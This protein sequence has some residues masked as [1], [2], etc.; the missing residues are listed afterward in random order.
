[1]TALLLAASVWPVSAGGQAGG[2]EAYAGRPVFEV[3]DSVRQQGYPI[4]YSSQLVPPTLTVVAEPV[5][6]EP[7][8]MLAEI[9]APHGLALKSADGIFLVVREEGAPPATGSGSLL[10]ISRD[11][12]SNLLKLPVNIRGSPPLPAAES[13]GAGVYRFAG[14]APGRYELDISAHGYEPT[15]KSV[16]IQSTDVAVLSV[17]LS[18]GVLELE[19]LT[20]STSRYILFANSQFFVD[21]RAIENLPDIG[22]DPVRSVHRLP[23]AAAGGWSAKSYFRGGEANETAI[24]LNGLKLLD[25]FH[26]RDYQNVFS[27]IDARSISGV[28]AYTGGFPANYGDRMSGLLILESQQP[29]K[30]RHTE[31]GISIFNTS[32][33]T[34]GYSDGG[35]FDWLLSARDSNLKYVLDKDLG[36]PSYNDIFMSAGF[37]PSPDTRL[38]LNALRAEDSILVVTESAPEEREQA[39][40]DTLNQSLW[41]TMENQWTPAVSSVTVLSS[42]SFENDRDGIVLDPEQLVGWVMD[43]RDV[44]ILELKQDWKWQAGPRHLLQFGFEARD[45]QAGYRYLS[46]AEYFGFYLAYPGVQESIQRDIT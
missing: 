24:Y 7:L 13:L 36:E 12:D 10:I 15:R 1:M 35:D 42:S 32:V 17:R 19:A 26:V 8:T 2:T 28:E 30:S 40:S 9:L 34:S 11:Q 5:S 33:L 20:V 37:N 3:L 16:E 18:L 6:G 44:D 45:Q 14:L 4:A 39:E 21:Q 38:T 25:P 27:S 41:L 29:E 22:N 43:D 23:G 46:E 31:L